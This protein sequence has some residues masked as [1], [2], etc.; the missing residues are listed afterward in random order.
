LFLVYRCRHHSYISHQ[1]KSRR[2]IG[3]CKIQHTTP[4]ICLP[5]DDTSISIECNVSSIDIEN[6]INKINKDLES[7]D[8]I[9]KLFQLTINSTKSKAIIISPKFN[10]ARIIYKNLTSIEINIEKIA[11]VD[12]LKYLG[13]HF[14]R[15]LSLLEHIRKI[16]QK[17][18]LSLSQLQPLKY[19]LPEHVK[20]NLVKTLV[21]PLFNYMDIVYH[22][23]DSHGSA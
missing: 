19:T 11:Y 4:T 9:C 12:I 13:Y 20:L 16:N 21:L 7:I 14:N 10:V 1:P 18:Y 6:V 5:L 22:E 23:H 2:H 8:E 17:V 3:W 15:E